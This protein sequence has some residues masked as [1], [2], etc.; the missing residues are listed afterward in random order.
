MQWES[1]HGHAHAALRY[2]LMS[3][4]GPSAPIIDLTLDDERAEA[5]RQSYLRERNEEEEME[6]VEFEFF[7][8]WDPW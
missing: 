3:R 1:N 4:P 8:A 2:G 7:S 6:D 5:L